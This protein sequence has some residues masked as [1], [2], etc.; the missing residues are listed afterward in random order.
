MKALRGSLSK[1]AAVQKNGTKILAPD[2]PLAVTHPIMHAAEIKKRNMG[3][4]KSMPW[5]FRSKA[6][7][8]ERKLL[9][10]NRLCTDTAVIGE[11]GCLP[12]SILRHSAGLS[13]ANAFAFSTL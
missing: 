2:L 13:G 3:K 5:A 1:I 7:I 6:Q 11:P 8:K 4:K 12:R 10:C 9:G